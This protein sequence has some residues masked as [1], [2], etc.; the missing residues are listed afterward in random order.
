L[1]HTQLKLR[2]G[3]I[4]HNNLKLD[5]FEILILYNSACHI[6]IFT[7]TKEEEAMTTDLSLSR[8]ALM[9]KLE[10]TKKGLGI[11][12]V[13]GRRTT[14]AANE[15]HFGIFVKEIVPKELAYYNGQLKVGDQLLEVNGTSLVGVSN[16]ELVYFNHSPF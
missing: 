8:N 9:V 3:S 16:S 2:R 15:E 5:I 12:I 1:S 13:G 6:R 14:H 11:K 7:S 4:L 10:G